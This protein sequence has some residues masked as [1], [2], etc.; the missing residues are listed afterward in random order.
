MH[1][2]TDFIERRA[3]GGNVCK[4]L[5]SGLAQVALDLDTCTDA[6]YRRA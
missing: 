4:D 6:K 2:H 1:R 3:N 5:K